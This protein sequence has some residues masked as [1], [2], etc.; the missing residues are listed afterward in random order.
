MA[1][2]ITT[3]LAQAE[4]IAAVLTI[5]SRQGSC[6]CS[7]L[8]TTLKQKDNLR[9]ATNN[10]NRCFTGSTTSITNS[11]NMTVSIG[12]KS[13]IRCSKGSKGSSSTV[14]RGTRRMQ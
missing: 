7:S 8:C 14:V 1:L 13:F 11:T 6:C 9:R 4:S 12:V 2:S 5:R 3:A 10:N